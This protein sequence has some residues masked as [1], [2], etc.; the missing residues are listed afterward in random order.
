M[1]TSPSQPIGKPGKYNRSFG[2]LVGALIMTA[3]TILVV[4]FL[5]GL[6]RNETETDVARVDL[7]DTVEA[8]QEGGLSPVYPAQLPE[9]WVATAAEVA[10]GEGGGFEIRLLTDPDATEESFVGIRLASDV[11]ATGLLTAYVDEET[12]DIESAEAYASDGDVAPTWEGYRDTS[13]DT[14]YVALLG[15]EAGE[16]VIV[17]GSAPAE[18]L[19]TVIDQLTRRPLQD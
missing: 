9:G 12:N 8:A 3:V 6:F 7:Y 11:S 2:G 13:G 19:Q 1:T 17:Y 16:I 10:T 15:N 5:M 14:A 4:L 18:D